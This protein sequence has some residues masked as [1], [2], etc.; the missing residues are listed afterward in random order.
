MPLRSF[1]DLIVWQKAM[2]LARETYCLVKLLPMEERY[3]LS[4][5][6]RRAAVSIPS[7]IAEGQSRN[8]KKEFIQFLHI[9]KGSNSE[10]MTQF[11]LC[12]DFEYLKKEEIQKVMKLCTEIDGLLG[13]LIKSL[14]TNLV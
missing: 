3:A 4:D 5:Q 13:G 1:R 6:M 7:N 11:L 14:K 8:T 2:R 9:A 10:L 12:L